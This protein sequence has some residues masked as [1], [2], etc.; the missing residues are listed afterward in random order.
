[1]VTFEYGLGSRENPCLVDVFRKGD[2]NVVESTPRQQG[3]MRMSDPRIMDLLIMLVASLAFVATTTE[4]LPAATFFPALVLFAIGAF[5]FLKSNST[6]MARAERRIE[7]RVNPALRQN[8]FAQQYAERLATM[9]GNPLIDR[10]EARAEESERQARV[11]S[12]RP[13]PSTQAEPIEID[14]LENEF[15]VTP[16]VSFPVEVQ[17]GDALVDELRKLN[18]LMSQGVLTEEEYAIAKSKLLD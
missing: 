10:G 6:E 12:G 8:Q 14:E 11:A 1:M 16:D 4:T 7:R 5:K 18:R 9:N 13:T 15:V 2:A 3:C 17:T